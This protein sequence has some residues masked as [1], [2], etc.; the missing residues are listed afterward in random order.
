MRN[1]VGHAPYVQRKN[2]KRKHR[3]E[4]NKKLARKGTERVRGNLR[5]RAIGD[6]KPRRKAETC[7]TETSAERNED[8]HLPVTPSTGPSPARLQG[9]LVVAVRSHGSEQLLSLVEDFGR[10]RRGITL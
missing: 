3:T 9:L 10:D 5:N 4:I 1:G 2:T 8:G 6:R 7:S